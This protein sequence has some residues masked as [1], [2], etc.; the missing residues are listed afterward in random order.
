MEAFKRK[1]KIALLPHYST[2]D[3]IPKR[4]LVS[5]CQVRCIISNYNGQKTINNDFSGHFTNLEN[6]LHFKCLFLYQQGI[7]T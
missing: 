5:P 1:L 7:G 4:E 2:I 6:K 3:H